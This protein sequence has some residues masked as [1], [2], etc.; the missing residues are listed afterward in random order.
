VDDLDLGFGEPFAAFTDRHAGVEQV[1]RAL[2]A[3]F[4]M[5][6]ILI[7]T[8]VTAGILAWKGFPRPAVWVTGAV[9]ATALLTSALKALLARPRPDYAHMQLS[10]G[11]F[12]SGHS[13][14][15]AALAGCAIV[16]A[17]LFLRRRNQRRWVV[18][19]AV[20]LALLLG[21]DRLMLGVHGITD[22]VA[23]YSL[24]AAV[25]L[26][27]LLLVDPTP[28][29]KPVQPLPTALPRSH[30]VLVILNPAKIENVAA[31]RQ[32]LDTRAAELGWNPPAWLETTVED[33][34]HSMARH[35]VEHRVDLVVVCGGDGTVRTVCGEL[36][37]SGIPVGV[38]PAGTGNLLARNLDVPLYLN[39]AI[40]VALNGQDRAVDLVRIQGDGIGE[41]EHFLV[42]AGMGFDAA[43]MG[44]VNE[45]IKAKVG[46]LAYFVSGVRNIMFPA[47]RL[48][49]SVDGG[50]ATKHWARTVVVGNVGFLQAGLPLLP[51]ATID[52]GRLDVVLVNPARFVH[53]FRVLFRVLSRGK[54]LDDTVNRMTGRTVTIRAH[55][56]T[57]RQVDGDAIEPGHEI[58]CEC[59]HGRLLVRAPR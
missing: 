16:L 52:D 23:G 2:A 14:G 29:A 4:R 59:L 19:G 25:V 11:A 51:D 40:E 58:R 12:P 32:M 9:V 1:A 20:L 55:G 5:V 57:P 3:A 6:P 54:K 34:G 15:T 49:V 7:L 24:A 26:G 33:P 35:A 46:W 10:D 38:V 50:P 42:M 18:V 17:F 43:I 8:A 27:G 21:L 36:A 41:R 30:E 28:R 31:F 13:S 48:E 47:V 37:G 56:E 39:A 44:G 53:W 45:Q 22:V